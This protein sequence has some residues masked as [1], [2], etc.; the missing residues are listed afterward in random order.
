MTYSAPDSKSQVTIEYDDGKPTRRS[1]FIRLSS[2][3]STTISTRNE[4]NMLAKIKEDVSSI[5]I[6]RVLPSELIDD[7]TIIHVNPTGKFVIGGP[8]GD[9]G[10]TGRKIIVDT[11]GGKGAHGGGA[12]SGKDSRKSTAR[13][14]MPHATSPKTWWPPALPTK[15]VQAAYAIGVSQPISINVDTYGT[16]MST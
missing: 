10:L 9:A 3:P 16:R 15:L 14:R 11:Y 13:R 12:F 5:V 6:P 4:K 2:R 7:N 1:V 8:H